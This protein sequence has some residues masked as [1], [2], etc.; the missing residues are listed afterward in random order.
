MTVDDFAN[1]LLREGLQLIQEGHYENRFGQT[2]Y[3]ATYRHGDQYYWFSISGTE[4]GFAPDEVAAAITHP[5][6]SIQREYP[7]LNTRGRLGFEATVRAGD[8]SFMLNAAPYPPSI[9]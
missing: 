4:I 8:H 9:L 6:R 3:R 2:G 7:Y 5:E 1:V